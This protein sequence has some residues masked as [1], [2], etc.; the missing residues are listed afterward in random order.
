MADKLISRMERLVAFMK[1][2]S[3]NLRAVKNFDYDGKLFNLISVA[4]SYS[5]HSS[6]LIDNIDSIYK[7]AIKTH[8][9]LSKSEKT[10]VNRM[11][12]QSALYTAKGDRIIEYVLQQFEGAFNL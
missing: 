11:K 7:K 2:S 4:T 12:E 6:C 3:S 8:K 1:A 9:P 10:Q 5:K